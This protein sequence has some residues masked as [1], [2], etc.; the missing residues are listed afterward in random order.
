MIDP[1]ESPAESAAPPGR[2]RGFGAFLRSVR[3]R[4]HRRPEM[5]RTGSKTGALITRSLESFGYEVRTGVAGGGIAAEAAWRDDHGIVLLADMDPQPIQDR[6]PLR[7]ASRVEGLMHACGHDGQVAALLGAAWLLSHSGLPLRFVFRPSVP[8]QALLD[9]G[10]F[11]GARAIV[12][13]HFDASRTT[14]RFFLPPAT[15]DLGIHWFKLEILG[16][17]C[18]AGYPREGPDPA[19]LGMH[20][21]ERLYALRQI[22]LTPY[23]GAALSVT[24]VHSGGGVDTRSLTIRGNVRTADADSKTRVLQG[25]ASLEPLVV[26]LGGRCRLHVVADTAVLRNDPSLEGMVRSVIRR[27]WGPEAL[28]PGL[29]LEAGSDNFAFLRSLGLPCLYFLAGAYRSRTRSRHHHRHFDLDEAALGHVARMLHLLAHE[30]G[31]HPH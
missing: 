29:H 25:L 18:H 23:H 3:R 7:Y 13:F 9:Q 17:R 10:L 30:I 5:A 8:A 12:G 16:T 20:V 4:L 28:T 11:S 2:T 14:G 15:A 26:S 31:A 19:W 24:D 22:E 21:L 27:H 1:D 6:K